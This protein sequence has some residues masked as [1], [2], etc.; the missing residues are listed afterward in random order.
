[1]SFGTGRLLFPTPCNY[2]RLSDVTINGD[3]NLSNSGVR[4]NRVAVNGAINVTGARS[5][6]SFEGDNTLSASV[7]VNVNTTDGVLGLEQSTTGT[8]TIGPSAVIQGGSI[9][10]GMSCDFNF[11]GTLLVNNGVIN[12]NIAGRSVT[13]NVFLTNNGTISATAGTVTT[14]TSVTNNGIMTASGSGS[15]TTGTGTPLINTG[16]IS[17]TTGAVAINS[18]LN[19]LIGTFTGGNL[20]FGGV[21][22]LGG[23]TWDLTNRT[24][25]LAHSGTVQNGTLLLGPGSVLLLPGQCAQAAFRNLTI[26]G[27]LILNN[28]GIRWSNVTHNGVIRVTGA[29]SSITFAGDNIFAARVEVSATG[30]GLVFEQSTAGTLTLAP[31]TVILGGNITFGRVCLSDPGMAVV[32]NGTINASMAGRTIGFNANVPLTNNGTIHAGPGNVTA[33]GNL[34]NYTAASGLLSGGIWRASGV[35]RLQLS[36]PTGMAFRNIAAGTLVRL[37]GP[38]ASMVNNN[39]GSVL[40]GVATLAGQM[41]IS[42]RAH[43]LAPVGGVLT[44]SGTLSLDRA[45]L[46]LT[47]GYVQTVTGTLALGVGG[48]AIAQYGRLAISGNATLA[49]AFV[50]QPAG[51]FVPAPGDV[52]DAVTASAV[53][54]VFGQRTGGG[55]YYPAVDYTAT[56]ARFS[57]LAC[58]TILSPLGDVVVCPLGAATFTTNVFGAAPLSYAWQRETPGGWVPLADGVLAG[59][60]TISGSLTDT[61]VVALPEVTGLRVRYMVSNICGSATSNAGTLIIAVRCSIAD[62]VGTSGGDVSCNDGVVDGADFIAFINSFSSGDVNVDAIADVAGAGIDGLEPDG[63]IDGGDFIAFINAFAAGC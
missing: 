22:D 44:N 53:T 9:Y 24:F 12:S 35:G 7:N 30:S 8:L 51:G 33:G 16:T 29:G 39:F 56:L 34:T 19:P 52:F 43:A 38:F 50:A 28:S 18:N 54:G 31:T 2:G 25:R 15:I 59:V 5:V 20:T 14:G 40:A 45:P 10:F 26:N 58:P 17:A 47:G 55:G 23:G 32:N 57:F 13:I 62:V 49:G 3:L 21:L 1:M 60:G 48:T 4:W 11:V 41:Q 63:I 46:T 61:L 6:I 42:S 36:S 37:D 27:D